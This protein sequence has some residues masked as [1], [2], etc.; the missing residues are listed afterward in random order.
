MDMTNLGC[1]ILSRFSCSSYKVTIK[2]Y[3][4]SYLTCSY[5]N[6]YSTLL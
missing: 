5:Y 3:S 1:D 4:L 6:N 2:M